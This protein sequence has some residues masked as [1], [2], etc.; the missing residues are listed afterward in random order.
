MY[1]LLSSTLGDWTEGLVH[2][3]QLLHCWASATVLFCLET[4][5]H[6]VDQADLAL[7]SETEADLE[8]GSFLPA[9]WV[10]GM[11]TAITKTGCI[12]V[13]QVTVSPLDSDR[14]KA[15]SEAYILGYLILEMQRAKILPMC[16]SNHAFPWHC[17]QR[18]IQMVKKF[19][20][21]P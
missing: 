1:L 21:C 5:S 10:V 11:Q 8:L 3:R 7:I 16:F 19:P 20:S 13:S 15:P 12:N 17:H 9:S 4:E 6:S 14:C 18:R 2:L